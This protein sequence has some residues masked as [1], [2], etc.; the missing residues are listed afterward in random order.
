ML[1]NFTLTTVAVNGCVCGVRAVVYVVSA[2]AGS[3]CS[4]S[5]VV[6]IDL[7]YS[8]CKLVDGVWTPEMALCNM[9]RTEFYAKLAS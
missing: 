1:D 8:R 2:D 3:G 6:G 9:L 5:G 4:C 7:K